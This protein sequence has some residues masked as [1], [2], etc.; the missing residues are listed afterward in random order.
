MK[1]FVYC[2]KSTE[3]E[4]HQVLSIE[5]QR[6]ELQKRFFSRDD[7]IV[8]D[9]FEESRTAKIPGRPIFNEM[10]KRIKHGDAD[11]I[12]AWHP[13]RLARNSIDGGQVIYF[14]DLGVVKDLKFASYTFENNSQG[15]FMLGIMFSNSKYYSDNL[16]ENVKRGN[17]TKVEKGWRPSAAPVGYLNDKDTRTTVKDPER[18]PIVRR[19]WDLML[20]GL[21]PPKKIH[22]I[23]MDEWGFR[24]RKRKRTGGGPLAVSAVYKMFANPFYVGIIKWEGRTYPGK[25]ASMITLEEFDRVQRMLN[26][27]YRPRPKTHCFAY[28]GLIRCGECGLSVTAEEK[29]NRYGYRYTYYRCTKKRL[30]SKCAQRS[31]EVDELEKQVSEFLKEITVP[32]K[33]HS[34][35]LKQLQKARAERSDSIDKMGPTL[36]KAIDA[37]CRELENL[38][39]LRLRDLI[40][41][42][43]FMSQRQRLDLERLKLQETLEKLRQTSSWFEPARLFISLSNRAISWFTAGDVETKRL[44]L[45]ITGSNLLLKDKKLLIEAAKPFK[46]QGKG[47]SFSQR[48]PLVDDV[49]TFY[50]DP[51]WE[52]KV[53]KLKRLSEIV[54]KKE[55]I[56]DEFKPAA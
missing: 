39:K 22:Q 27:N 50:M 4:D 52:D 15:K 11:G 28:T 55:A 37:I 30:A 33:I 48:C 47:G 14:L 24:T 1:Y 19:M 23:A 54:G 9:V 49:R 13:D 5:S 12:I 43:E 32:D 34:W 53:R 10:L 20:T 16:S 25:H 21:Y 40:T 17:R 29:I 45:E 44:I 35:A 51:D 56:S 6:T 3:D 7:I 26:D 41:D 8:V 2:R 18:F 38:T 46:R 31:I 42:D 36:E